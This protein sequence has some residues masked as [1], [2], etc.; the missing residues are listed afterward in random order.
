M[1]FFLFTTRKNTV[2]K[3]HDVVCLNSF[4]F[5]RWCPTG[6]FVAAGVTERVWLPSDDEALA[7]KRRLRRTGEAGRRDSR[8]FV[9]DET[10]VS[11][12][13]AAPTGSA[14][15]PACLSSA[16]RS[17]M[18]TL[19]ERE[20]RIEVLETD[21]RRLREGERAAVESGERALE[22]EEAVAASLRVEVRGEGGGDK[23]S[24]NCFVLFLCRSRVG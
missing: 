24:S 7:E 6:F 23:I 18:N 17:L 1:L 19:Q 9:P 15:S 2:N 20:N 22:K 10:A 21:V 3:A 11:S 16:V 5:S 13:S 4:V 8:R 14:S 12:A